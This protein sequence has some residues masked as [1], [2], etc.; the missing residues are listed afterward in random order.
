MHAGDGSK[1]LYFSAGSS[2]TWNRDDPPPCT[3]DP[4]KKQTST[5]I[6]FSV[7]RPVSACRT[8]KQCSVRKVVFPCRHLD[9]SKYN[10]FIFQRIVQR[11]LCVP[12]T[13][14]LADNDVPRFDPMDCRGGHHVAQDAGDPL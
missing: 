7:G 14:P 9:T 6:F 11:L 8:D 1:K 13:P 4:A 12:Q 5:E 2:V 10:V 3:Q